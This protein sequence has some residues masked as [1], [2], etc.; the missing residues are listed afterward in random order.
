MNIV[1]NG[2]TCTVADDDAMLIDVVR[3]GGLTGT[4]LVCGSGVC[5]A[6]TVLLDGKPVASCLMPAKAARDR[7]VTT[8]EGIAVSELHP[9]QK[10]FIACD[11]L[12]CGFCTPRFVVEAAAFH[13]AWRRDKGTVTPPRADVTAAFAGHLHVTAGIS[14]HARRV[15]IADTLLQ[16]CTIGMISIPSRTLLSRIPRTATLGQTCHSWF[17]TGGSQGSGTIV[18]TRL[19]EQSP[20]AT[21]Q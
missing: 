10:A 5:G 12:Q 9:V 4:K 21:A 2:E 16:P 3:N 13:D 14:Q 7:Q 20:R 1:I 17:G 15:G 8:V 18:S 19:Y 6:C 11:A